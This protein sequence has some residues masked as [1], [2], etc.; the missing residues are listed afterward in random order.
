[1]HPILSDTRRTAI[2]LVMWGLLGLVAGAVIASATGS[3]I[4][5]AMAFAIPLLLVFAEM[6]LS[7]WY[8]S[9]TFPL[10]SLPGWRGLLGVA[11][12][13]LTICVVWGAAGWGWLAA[14][15]YLFGVVLYP[16]DGAVILA[17][18]AAAGVPVYII[19]LTA[20]YLIAAFERSRAAEQ[21]AF[22]MRLQAQNAELKALRMQIDPH[23]LFNS[24]NSIA[25]LTSADPAAARTMTT[26]L[27]DFFRKSLVFGA[28][29]RVTVEEEFSLLRSYLDIEKVR[30]GRRLSVSERVEESARACLLPPL[31]LQPLL[32]NAIKHGIADSLEGGTVTVT[33]ERR[34]DRLF[35][36]VENPT[37]P[38][39]PERSGT[40]SGID[41][42][43]RRLRTSYGE[44]AGLQSS[45]RENIFQVVLFMPA[46]EQR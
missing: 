38:G 1:M 3:R 41:I 30:F 44:E 6:N 13:V 33:A 23:F 15:Q 34:S 29:E 7:A 19:S 35:L 2:Y 25:A 28:K 18:I 9:R 32:E 42:V 20:S 36:T 22:E 31:L 37:E 5:P 17:G 46:G 10:E 8:I 12:S 11:A 4:L 40:G 24:L 16:Y 14:V 21:R 39:S 26:T 43:R 27:A 45:L